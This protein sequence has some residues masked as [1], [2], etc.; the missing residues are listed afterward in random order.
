MKNKNKLGL[1]NIYNVYLKKNHNHTQIKMKKINLDNLNDTQNLVIA[2]IV[3]IIGL[4]I[5]ETIG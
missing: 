4:C 3:L 2:L 5:G 1:N